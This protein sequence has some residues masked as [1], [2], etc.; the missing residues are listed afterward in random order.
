MSTTLTDLLEPHKPWYRYG[1]RSL[2]I[3][4]ARS[5]NKHR[6]IFRLQMALQRATRGYGENDLWSV[7]YALA[8]LTVEGCRYMRKHGHG[9]PMEL[10][11]E[12]WDAILLQMQEGFQLW[13]DE[14]GWLRDDDQEAKFEHA[15]DLYAKW[16]SGLWD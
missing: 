1:R 11:P 3:L 4:L 9:H 8:K 15:M 16:F 2:P 6:P 10:T 13:I 12:E 14:D 5:R 7:N